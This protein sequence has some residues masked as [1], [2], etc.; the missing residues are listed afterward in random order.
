MAEERRDARGRSTPPPIPSNVRKA[1]IPPL[2]RLFDWIGHR[3]KFLPT[4]LGGVALLVLL[5]KLYGGNPSAA[6]LAERTSRSVVV[7]HESGTRGSGLGS[8]FFVDD[9]LI[10]TNY[11]VIRN[12]STLRI[13]LQ[14]GAFLDSA[15]VVR[16][17][18]THD[19]ALLR[20][21]YRGSPLRL[22]N[23]DVIVQGSRVFALGHPEGLAY[24][25]SEGIVSS[26]RDID[27]VRVLQITAPLSPGSSGGPVINEQ[28]QVVGISTAVLTVGQN[29]NFAV[30]ASH[31]RDFLASSSQ[32]KA[33]SRTVEGRGLEPLME[34]GVYA[35]SYNI[36]NT[37]RDKVTFYVLSAR[38]SLIARVGDSTDWTEPW[39]KFAGPAAGFPFT[40]D[41]ARKNVRVRFDS[42]AS[43][44]LVSGHFEIH[45]YGDVTQIPFTAAK[46]RELLS[47]KAVVLLS[48]PATGSRPDGFGKG[49]HG[50]SIAG[51]LE[52]RDA[53]PSTILGFFEPYKNPGP[54]PAGIPAFADTLYGKI[55]GDTIRF[56]FG[57]VSCSLPKADWPIGKG[58]CWTKSHWFG[59]T[60]ADATDTATS[61]V[62]WTVV[63]RNFIRIIS[64]RLTETDGVQLEYLVRANGDT[65][66]PSGAGTYAAEF[67]TLS[68]YSPVPEKEAWP[69]T[70][71]R[72]EFHRNVLTHGEVGS[73]GPRLLVTRVGNR[74]DTIPV[75][76]EILPGIPDSIIN[77]GYVP[78][79]PGS[80]FA[81]WRVGK[82]CS[83]LFWWNLTVAETRALPP[84][85]VFGAFYDGHSR[86]WKKV[87]MKPQVGAS[88]ALLDAIS[89]NGVLSR[90]EQDEPAIA[91]PVTRYFLIDPQR[92]E[93][94]VPPPLPDSASKKLYTRSSVVSGDDYWAITRY[95]SRDEH[96]CWDRNDLPSLLIRWRPGR[97]AEV[98]AID[99]SRAL[100]GAELIATS[101]GRILVRTASTLRLAA[102]G[103]PVLSQRSTGDQDIEF[104]LE[105]PITGRLALVSSTGEVSVLRLD[106]RL[107]QYSR[108][109][110]WSRMWRWM[111][112]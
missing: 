47:G 102:N 73:L 91:E 88:F 4:V 63:P 68:D 41:Y 53:G 79:L 83:Y 1:R 55:F 89:E 19:L 59:L 56:T 48:G 67:A 35:V 43:T 11:H 17:D 64:A 76:P 62:F 25:F 69:S 42:A 39:G 85:N 104:A 20:V 8:G 6:T 13:E 100:V 98:V 34:S 14:D 77:G 72:R 81:Q 82:A 105:D 108:P 40:V 109:T 87:S 107:P 15:T 112:H 58:A 18:P 27:G 10:L 45:E 111:G 65:V 3:K 54:P 61:R 50:V 2:L 26:I 9:S 95:C 57:K 99:S 80:F 90:L 94:E 24:T 30:S 86:R 52:W 66:H 70:L 93:Q 74:W 71:N 22:P 37:H 60:A 110:F 96:L 29:L 28:G 92:G 5:I 16:A 21:R 49:E 31:I 51:D 46:S 36:G 84:C 44:N 23:R 78:F 75:P 97:S 33:S 32:G 103:F 12:A 101:A 7:I 38:D 106:P